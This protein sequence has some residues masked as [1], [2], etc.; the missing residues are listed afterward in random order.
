[1][2][3]LTDLTGWCGAL[4]VLCA[5]FLTLVMDW[6]VESGRYIIL[7][8][9]AAVLLCVNAALSGASPFLVINLAMIIIAVYKVSREGWPAW[10]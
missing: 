1:M 7:T 2:E 10:K 9:T 3:V 6:K 4:I 8:C 5:Y